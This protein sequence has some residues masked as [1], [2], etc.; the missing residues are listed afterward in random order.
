MSVSNEKLLE[1]FA[2]V[3]DLRG[4]ALSR[5]S[6]CKEFVNK[7]AIRAGEH[8]DITAM[9]AA[10]VERRALQTVINLLDGVPAKMPDPDV[11]LAPPFKISESKVDDGNGERT[12]LLGTMADGYQIQIDVEGGNGYQRRLELGRK[13]LKEKLQARVASGALDR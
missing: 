1:V 4:W 8:G 2:R 11:D 5:I 3:E 9:R 13:I 10:E 7:E 12:E 6:F